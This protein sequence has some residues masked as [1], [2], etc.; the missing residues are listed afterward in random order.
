M[1]TESK[2]I[3]ETL[4]P[5]LN[6][7]NDL[8]GKF[9]FRDDEGR[10]FVLMSEDEM[11]KDQFEIE[12]IEQQL[13]LPEISTIA[14]AIRNNISSEIADDVIERIN[15]D[16]A[17]THAQEQ[18]LEEDEMDDLATMVVEDDDLSTYTR[19]APPAPPQIRFESV[20]GDLNPAL[21]D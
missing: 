17:M 16:I 6:I 3:K 18:D 13:E 15:K 5:I 20:R 9:S 11:L 19:P 2:N 21:Q 4:E 8:G 10:V 12:E 1:Q 14:D 7:L